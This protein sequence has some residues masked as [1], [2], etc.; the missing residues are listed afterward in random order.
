MVLVSVVG[1]QL[2]PSQKILGGPS[3]LIILGPFSSPTG[4]ENGVPTSPEFGIPNHLSQ[5]ALHLVP[6]HGVPKAFAHHESK[7]AMT[8]PVGQNTNN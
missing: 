3:Q 2:S 5:S 1:Y 8:Q 7:A 6:D 4:D